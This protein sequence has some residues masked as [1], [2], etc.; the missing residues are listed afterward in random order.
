MSRILSKFLGRSK[1]TLRAGYFKREWPAINEKAAF[2]VHLFG[3][4][5]QVAVS[6]PEQP[7]MSLD[8][9]FKMAT[10]GLRSLLRLG[11]ITGPRVFLRSR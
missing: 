5:T 6:H 1:E 9:N 11:A 10:S 3:A 8:S 7:R 2:E 4:C